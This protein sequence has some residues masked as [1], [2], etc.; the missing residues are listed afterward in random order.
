VRN[1]AGRTKGDV[2]DRQPHRS[3]LQI[4]LGTLRTR[5]VYACHDAKDKFERD[6][7]AALNKVMNLDRFDRG[8]SSISDRAQD[9]YWAG[10]AVCAKNSLRTAALEDWG[11]AR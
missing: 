6:F 10:S 4:E 7:A 9:R 3:R 8:R 2:R 11:A 1:P 5:A